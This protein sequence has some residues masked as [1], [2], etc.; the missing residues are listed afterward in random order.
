MTHPK[1]NQKGLQD[2]MS[3]LFH[4]VIGWTVYIKHNFWPRVRACEALRYK[5]DVFVHLPR[6]SL[7]TSTDAMGRSFFFHDTQRHNTVPRS[8]CRA[9][10]HLNLYF[11]Q[12][13]SNCIS[14]A[15]IL[16]A[17]VFILHWALPSDCAHTQLSW[18]YR[19]WFYGGFLFYS[20]C[21]CWTI[22]LISVTEKW[23]YCSFRADWRTVYSR[24]L[25]KLAQ[26]EMMCESQKTTAVILLLRMQM[27]RKHK[28]WKNGVKI[29]FLPFITSLRCRNELLNSVWWSLMSHCHWLSIGSR[30]KRSIKHL[31]SEGEREL[32]SK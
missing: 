12:S 31:E 10:F 3:L 27:P 17:L 15:S 6:S 28:K 24:W 26:S 21:G 20:S 25:E 14:A 13:L 2:V 7:Y 9:I 19:N 4:Q 11:P 23:V 5:P 30:E 18:T 32:Q 8:Q 29:H 1:K 22:L 16:P